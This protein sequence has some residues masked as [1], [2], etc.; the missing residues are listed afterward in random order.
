MALTPTH[1]AGINCIFLLVLLSP[2]RTVSIY[3]LEEIIKLK[4][5]V[6]HPG[7]ALAELGAQSRAGPGVCA[8]WVCCCAV[9]STPHTWLVSL[10]R[11][12]VSLGEGSFNEQGL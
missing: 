3:S 11:V 2:E 1:K 10:E 12:F 8:E 9:L 6:R 4:A 5:T 7:E